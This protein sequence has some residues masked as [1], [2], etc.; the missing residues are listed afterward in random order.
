[1]STEPWYEAGLRFGCTHCGN[2]CKS[3]G[4]Y[5]Y[6]Y[7]MEPEVEAIA[8]HLGLEVEVFRERHTEV[9]E[10]W[11]VIRTSRSASTS[12]SRACPFLAEDNRC[13]IYPVRPVQ[14]RTWPFWD[15]NLRRKTTWE[16]PVRDTC[17]GI[18][19]GRLY[20]ADEIETIARG[21]EEWYADQD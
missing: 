17:P 1:M 12:S 4:E 5:A 20:T 13:G 2:C 6:I 9:D 8:E 14:C 19:E 11:T 3:H 15:E 10:G 21:N 16:G 18:G 7:L